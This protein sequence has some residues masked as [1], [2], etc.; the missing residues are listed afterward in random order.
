M[1]TGFT[2][3]MKILNCTSLRTYVDESATTQ[4]Q[5]SPRA[6]RLGTAMGTVARR[7]IGRRDWQPI[8]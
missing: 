3:H 4:M 8:S 7:K 1:W 6:T 5:R 2:D